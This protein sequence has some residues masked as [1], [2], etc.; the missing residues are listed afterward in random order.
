[1]PTNLF[2]PTE[3]KAQKP[4]QAHYIFKMANKDLKMLNLSEI[5]QIQ[6]IKPYKVSLH[7]IRTAPWK[8]DSTDSWLGH[9]AAG[10]D[11]LCW[12]QSK[13]VQPLWERLGISY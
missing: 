13:L 1:M 4:A 5:R 6:K 9:K 12:W 10:T 3:K 2:L 8:S 7:S 11:I